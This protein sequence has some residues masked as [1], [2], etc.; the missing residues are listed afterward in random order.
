MFEKS[1]N[2][3]HDDENY[4]LNRPILH[5][6]QAAIIMIIIIGPRIV[7]HVINKET[8]EQL[9]YVCF[10]AKHFFDTW[11]CKIAYKLKFY[12]IPILTHQNSQSF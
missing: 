9:M 8:K 2:D 5:V 12:R 6:E 3:D 10:D 4:S 1:G 7:V 11:I